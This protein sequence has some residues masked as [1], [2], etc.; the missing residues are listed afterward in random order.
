MS[1]AAP[2][3]VATRAARPRPG[4]QEFSTLYENEMAKLMRFVMK[5]GA[6]TTE[7]TD[8]AQ[9]A[10]SLAWGSWDRIREPKAWLRTVAVREYLRRPPVETPIDAVPDR[11]A[12]PLLDSVELGEQEQ[13]VMDALHTLPMKQRQVM[14]WHYDGFPNAQIAKEMG[15]NE[16]AV[17]QNLHRARERLKELLLRTAGEAGDE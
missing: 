16:A 14:A 13:R 5:H 1:D 9:S 15:I 6:S 3:R 12:F 4:V 2:E 7:A 17:R 10:F 11:A 8:A